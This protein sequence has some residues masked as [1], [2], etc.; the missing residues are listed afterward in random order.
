M[1]LG[2]AFCGHHRMPYVQLVLLFRRVWLV[3]GA[4][5]RVCVTPGYV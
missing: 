3:L 5:T 4:G 2:H 1:A